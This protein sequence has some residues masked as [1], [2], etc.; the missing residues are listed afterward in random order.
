MAD[1]QKEKPAEKTAE[2]AEKGNN[3]EKPPAPRPPTPEKRQ[4]NS[5][6]PDRFSIRQPRRRVATMSFRKVE[7]Q[8]QVIPACSH[9]SRALA[10]SR[11]G[12]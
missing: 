10:G 9:R 12:A 6:D 7:T 3:G 1:K 11:D 2:S 5:I 8:R 4:L